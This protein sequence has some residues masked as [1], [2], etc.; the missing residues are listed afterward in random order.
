[1]TGARGSSAH[2]TAAT[3]SRSGASATS[4]SAAKT[5][6]SARLVIRYSASATAHRQLRQLESRVF[7][8]LPHQPPPE[9]L[10]VASRPAPATGA[11]PCSDQPAL[12]VRVEGFHLR[13]PLQ[14]RGRLRPA[15]L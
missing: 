3:I 6:S 8:E 10:V 7:P 15:G 11:Q 14:R 13:K 2:T 1:M 12:N 5:M 4:A 9:R